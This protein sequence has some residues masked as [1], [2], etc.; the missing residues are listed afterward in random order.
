MPTSSHKNEKIDELYERIS[1]VIEMAKGNVQ[2]NYTKGFECNCW[3][4]DRMKS[5]RNVMPG[6]RNQ[7]T[8][9]LEK[10]QVKQSKSYPGEFKPSFCK[11]E[12]KIVS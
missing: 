1:E 12:N 4:K 5:N 7:T 10:I 9:Q 2:F 6:G 3:R 8:Y 11:H